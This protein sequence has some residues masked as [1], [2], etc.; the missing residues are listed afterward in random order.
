MTTD[1]ATLCELWSCKSEKEKETDLVK[2]RF[3]K[4]IDHSQLKRERESN[5]LGCRIPAQIFKSNCSSLFW[6][7]AKNNFHKDV[8]LCFGN[9][10]VS[11]FV[12]IIF[13]AEGVKSRRSYFLFK[14]LEDVGKILSPIN[15][16]SLTY[17]V[18]RKLENYHQ[19]MQ[20]YL[21]FRGS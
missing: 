10:F 20:I 21:M 4:A 3:K 13:N 9:L 17:L 5:E 2:R 1:F 18:K 7:E 15:W 19:K 14:A 12:S 6:Q 11:A 8:H 16:L